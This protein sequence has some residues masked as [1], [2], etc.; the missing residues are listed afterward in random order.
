MRVL[1]TGAS[2][3]VGKKTCLY[4]SKIGHEVSAH[5]RNYSKFPLKIKFI[6]G[7]SLLNNSPKG[8][9]LRGYE[10]VVHLAGKTP[11][12]DSKTNDSYSEYFKA[13][14]QETLKLAEFCAKSSVKRFIFMSS[15]KVNGESTL[16]NE[17][18]SENDIPNPN[19]Y[20]AR[21]KYEAELGLLKIA[22]KSNMEVV[23]VRPPLIYGKGVKGYFRTILKLIK[24][25]IPIP[26]GS[27]NQNKRSYIY[28]ENLVNFIAVLIEHPNAGNQI[29][30]CSD[31]YDLSTSELLELISF[32]MHKKNFI[33]RFPKFLIL[34]SYILGKGNL[35][36]KISQSLT[37]DN[38]KSAKLLNWH[39]PV[40]T[41]NALKRVAKEFIQ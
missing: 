30:L 2:G 9:L 40:R 39:P 27:F 33:F 5:S 34:I 6:E 1:I 26:L 15:I 25:K 32:G 20:Y 3:F 36:K 19:D 4:L 41:K 22:K 28:L 17:P 23:I 18:F 35:Y 29:F 12:K 14:V 37:I 31:N 8:F 21:S 13:N 11:A 16:E 24:L 38:S 10:C 7:K